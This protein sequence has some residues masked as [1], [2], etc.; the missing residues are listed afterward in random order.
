MKIIKAYPPNFAALRKAFPAI[1][2]NKDIIF[3]FGDRIFNPGG[4]KLSPWLIAHEEVHC[5]RQRQ[6]GVEAWWRTYADNRQVRLLEEVLA[7]KAELA[8]FKRAHHPN[9]YETFRLAL[10]KRLASPIYG[11]MVSA[12]EAMGHL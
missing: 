11:P 3:S 5:Y 1:T 9:E 10:A 2:G 4:R 7:H 8:E 12:E 6:L